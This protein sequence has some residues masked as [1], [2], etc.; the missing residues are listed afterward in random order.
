[1]AKTLFTEEKRQELQ[2]LSEKT[3]KYPLA[4]REATDKEISIAASVGANK[5][6]NVLGLK[7]GG[8]GFGPQVIVQ[9]YEKILAKA[10]EPAIKDVATKL[11]EP[12]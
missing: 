2:G 6:L 5:A 7:V 12:Q 8:S 11:L 3:W 10:I 4:K 9:R 1:M